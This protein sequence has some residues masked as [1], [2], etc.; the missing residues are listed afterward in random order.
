M[1]YFHTTKGCDFCLIEFE[2]KNDPLKY[3]QLSSS[4]LLNESQLLEI[5]H[6]HKEIIQCDSN[7]I[8][9]MINMRVEINHAISNGE[10]YALVI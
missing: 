8:I 2:E 9:E 3:N 1:Q 7:F 4:Y 5:I 10:L 6:T